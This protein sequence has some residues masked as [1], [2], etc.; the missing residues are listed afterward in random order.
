MNHRIINNINNKTESK[1]DIISLNRILQLILVEQDKKS[2]EENKEFIDNKDIC[3][4]YDT[5]IEKY[6]RER[7]E[8][9][10]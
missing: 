6:C 1:N 4:V 8:D 5:N 9:E 10:R 3:Y 7:R 2:I